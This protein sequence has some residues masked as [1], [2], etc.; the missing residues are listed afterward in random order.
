MSD[1][2]LNYIFK[3]LKGIKPLEEPEWFSILGFL[4]LHRIEGLFYK[5]ALELDIFLPLKVKKNLKKSFDRQKRRVE[6]MKD[7]V[8]ELSLELIQL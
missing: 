2:S 3:I 4:S 1:E 8:E 5:K 7:Y 6:F